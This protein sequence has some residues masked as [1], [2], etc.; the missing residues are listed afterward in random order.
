M[1]DLRVGVRKSD[2]I[3]PLP[4]TTRV[5]FKTKT[6]VISVQLDDDSET[7]VVYSTDKMFVQPAAANKVYI[8]NK[9]FWP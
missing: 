8:H 4:A 7:L 2:H 5:E 9:P 6:G 3:E 1:T